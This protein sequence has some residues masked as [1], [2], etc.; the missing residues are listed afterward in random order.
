MGLGL[1]ALYSLHNP[2]MLKLCVLFNIFMDAGDIVSIVPTL[3]KREGIDRAAISCG[4]LALFGG[5]CW[6]IAWTQL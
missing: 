2:E 6:L 4:C 5:T 1:L 3:F